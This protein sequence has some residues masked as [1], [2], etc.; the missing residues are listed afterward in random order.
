M[1]RRAIE[2]CIGQ[3]VPCEIVVID[4]GSEDDTPEVVKGIPRLKYIRHE[5]PLG[6][7]TAANR[8]I[9]E[10]DAEWIKPLDD[11][12]WLAPD[13][14]E[15]MSAVIEMARTKGFNPVIISGRAVNVDESGRELGHSRSMADFPVSIKSK[16]QLRLMLLDLSPIGTPVQVGHDRE[17][18]LRVGG[19]NERRSFDHQ[20]G[21][22]LELWI[23]LAGQG[24][25]LFIPSL[26]AYRTIWTGA[27]QSRI[28]PDERYRS[29]LFVKELIAA[30]LGEQ[31]PGSVKNYLALHWALVAAKSGMYRQALPLGLIWLKRPDSIFHLFEMQSPKKAL[32]VVTRLDQN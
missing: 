2:S 19:W 24:D 28:P 5:R 27:S 21:D 17:A 32:K 8:G 29:N 14:L 7:S 12:D 22:E 4:E 15:K 6:H 3:T 9:Q 30:E 18:A 16:D 1:L 26:V 13:C 23:K 20:H 25:C 31:V 11:D 10:A